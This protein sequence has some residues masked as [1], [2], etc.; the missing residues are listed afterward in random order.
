MSPES[1]KVRV[2]FAKSAAKNDMYEW[3][4]R[5]RDRRDSAERE[6]L[7]RAMA[8]QNESVKKNDGHAICVGEK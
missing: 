5:D 6:G 3:I 8:L 7:L 2:D 4:Q 1:V